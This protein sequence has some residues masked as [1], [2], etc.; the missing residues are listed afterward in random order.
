LRD[1]KR[2]L[3]WRIVGRR[4]FGFADVILRHRF[5]TRYNDLPM[6]PRQRITAA[7]AI[8]LLA[9]AIGRPT[10]VAA[11]AAQQG[12]SCAANGTTV[13]AAQA[14]GGQNLICT[15]GTWQYVPYQFGSSAATCNSTKAG[16]IFWN[17]TT[18]EY[19]NGTTWGA[20][21]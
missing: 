3:R 19:C 8:T 5:L 1:A 7:A 20:F 10:P 4:Q 12:T 18:F 13:A 16:M 2:R 9:V 6:L 11:A 17:G 14:S 21:N 15:S